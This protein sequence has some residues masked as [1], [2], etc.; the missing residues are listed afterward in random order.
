MNSKNFWFG[1]ISASFAKIYHS[2]PKH[3]FPDGGKFRLP[4]FLALFACTGSAAKLSVL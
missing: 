1:V 3:A 4:R 2:A